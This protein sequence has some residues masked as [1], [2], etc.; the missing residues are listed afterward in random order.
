MW[1]ECDKLWL[2]E[3]EAD[4]KDSNTTP[5]DAEAD[6]LATVQSKESWATSINHR[7]QA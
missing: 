2:G 6:I 3:F 1:T 5:T 7:G 4:M